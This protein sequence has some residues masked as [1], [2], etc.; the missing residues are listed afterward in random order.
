MIHLIP[1][2]AGAA[3][4]IGAVLFAKSDKTKLKEGKQIAIDKAKEGIEALKAT[5][6]CISEKIASKKEVQAP[7]K[8][9]EQHQN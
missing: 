9:D 7:E 2:I 5:K 4:G 3:V 8:T 6:A 1:F